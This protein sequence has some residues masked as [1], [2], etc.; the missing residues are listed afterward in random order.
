MSTD[1]L[2]SGAH[3]LRALAARW[4]LLA[5]GPVLV[6]AAA[7]GITY[8]IAPTFTARTIFLPPQPAATSTTAALATLGAITGATANIPGLRTGPDQHVA[9]LQT[10][11]VRDRLVDRFDLLR[12]YDKELRIDARN[13]LADNV[14]IALGRRDGLVTVEVDDRD[15]KRAADIANAHVD[16][17]RRLGATLAI[18]EAQ[19][20]R[21]FFERQLAQT[22]DRLAAA[23][24]ALRGSGF[25]AGAL[26]AEPR[27]AAESYARLRA[28][29]TA[30]EVRLQSMRSAL[31][32]SAPEL[33]QQRSVVSALRAELARAEQAQAPSGD[34]DYTARYREFK[35]QETLFDLFARHY[36]MA[37]VDEAR[38]GALIQ[39]VDV[40]Q[41]PEKKS[42]PKRLLTAAAAGAVAALLL[43]AWVALGAARSSRAHL[44]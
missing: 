23:Q 25:D 42:K 10:D 39:V 27:A 4:K 30:A 26:K 13:K 6:A 5:F 32:D 33:V 35:Y 31:V 41:P 9:L 18:T 17:L 3:L 20:R 19:Q 36:E 28:E 12:V 1:G 8:L 38:E 44:A 2:D 11:N 43:L 21:A 22:R 14:R 40:A 7:L 24:L 37:R 15:P 29:T 16:E 34:A